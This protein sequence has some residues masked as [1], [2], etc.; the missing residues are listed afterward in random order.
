MQLSDLS[1]ISLLVQVTVYQ[2]NEGKGFPVLDHP[3]SP[4]EDIFICSYEDLPGTVLKTQQ[5]SEF[6]IMIA[7]VH[8]LCICPREQG[9][10]FFHV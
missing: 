2:P 6:I 7:K 5:D 9:I 8:V 10:I 4:P 3:P 1:I